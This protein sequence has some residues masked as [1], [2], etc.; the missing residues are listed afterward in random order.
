M[1]AVRFTRKYS[2]GFTELIYS[3]MDEAQTIVNEFVTKLLNLKVGEGEK[4][5]Y[6]IQTTCLTGSFALS[7]IDFIGVNAID[8]DEEKNF[9]VGFLRRRGEIELLAKGTPAVPQGV[10][11]I[12]PSPPRSQ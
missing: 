6:I 8:L 10:S 11:V 7:V 4:T 2:E 3:T 1:F 9:I 12:S 5:D